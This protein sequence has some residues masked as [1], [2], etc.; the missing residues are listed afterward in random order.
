MSGFPVRTAG[1]W[2][3][4][5]NSVP[6]GRLSYAYHCKRSMTYILN[7][8]VSHH[9]FGVQPYGSINCRRKITIVEV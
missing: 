4:P 9:Y 8:A 1:G 2:Q 7:V 3:M 6:A 5:S